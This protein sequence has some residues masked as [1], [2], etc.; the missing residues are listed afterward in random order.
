MQSK[1]TKLSFRKQKRWL[2]F[3]FTLWE[4]ESLVSRLGY[5]ALVR[6]YVLK[7]KSFE[8]KPSFLH[9]SKIDFMSRRVRLSKY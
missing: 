9:R 7:K 3:K 8:F 4:Y 1:Q 6:Q 5:L 2:E